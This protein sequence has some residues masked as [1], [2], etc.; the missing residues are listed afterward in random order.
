M[1]APNRSKTDARCPKNKRRRPNDL[2]KASRCPTRLREALGRPE[3]TTK[4]ACGEA[5]GLKKTM[6]QV[7][8]HMPCF[9]NFFAA[10]CL[11]NILNKEAAQTAQDG[12]RAA[13]ARR[14][15]PV[16]GGPRSI[17]NATFRD[18][19]GLP[20]AAIETLGG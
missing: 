8:K 15:S 9:R 16:L 2:P 12:I 3:E 13:G 10:N 19:T 17:A 11:G 6:E 18:I 20:E 7:W 4:V 1:T 5:W 14:G